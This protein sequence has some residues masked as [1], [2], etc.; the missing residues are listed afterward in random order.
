MYL[1]RG[2]T[3]NTS[4]SDADVQATTL[5]SA[6]FEG[7]PWWEYQLPATF[8]PEAAD[9]VRKA[10]QPQRSRIDV[11][12]VECHEWMRQLE[13]DMQADTDESDA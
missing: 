13:A 7:R 3:R 4:N 5:E 9:L 11:A 1:L 10:L 2:V 6:C 8:P 12:E